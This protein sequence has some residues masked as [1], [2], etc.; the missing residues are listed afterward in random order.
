MYCLD[1]GFQLS[2]TAEAGSTVAYFCLNPDCRQVYVYIP[3]AVSGPQIA[4]F[5]NL[6]AA[7]SSLEAEG[8]GLRIRHLFTEETLLD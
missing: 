8:E 5:D 7:C 4:I 6:D 2:A 1:C 3:D